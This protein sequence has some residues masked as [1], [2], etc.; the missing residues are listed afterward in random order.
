MKDGK[1][2]GYGIN[3]RKWWDGYWIRV[4]GMMVHEFVRERR[5]WWWWV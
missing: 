1:V 3:E 5:V 2:T 4:V